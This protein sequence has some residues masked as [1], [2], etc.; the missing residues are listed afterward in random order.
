METPEFQDLSRRERQLLEIIYAEGEAS[1]SDVRSKMPDP[2]SYS[3]V[4]TILGILEEKGRL[5]HRQEGPRYLYRPAVP[6]EAAR[7][8]VLKNLVE[9]FF[10]GSA[11]AAAVALLRMEDTRLGGLALDRLE[12][13]IERVRKEG[14]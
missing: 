10:D 3:S 11:G 5:V 2:P 14:R 9:T 13:E 4:R 6:R 7:R 12:E 1:V 8:A